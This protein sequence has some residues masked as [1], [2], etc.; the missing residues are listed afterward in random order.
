MVKNPKKPEY[1]TEDKLSDY[2]TKEA[3][4]K[5]SDSLTGSIRSYFKRVKARFVD[6]AKRLSGVEEG[7]ENAK[8]DA[9]AAKKKIDELNP[10]VEHLVDMVEAIASG[11]AHPELSGTVVGMLKNIEALARIP[12]SYKPENKSVSLYDSEGKKTEKFVPSDQYK[13]FVVVLADTKMPKDAGEGA[14]VI[15]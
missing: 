10:T 11:E 8:K 3:L 13:K 1:V 7:V 14:A 9:E 6:Y 15:T 5:Q 4:S 12:V 2:A